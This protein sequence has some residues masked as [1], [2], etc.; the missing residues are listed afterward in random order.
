MLDISKELNH[1]EALVRSLGS[2]GIEVLGG[3]YTGGI[4]LQQSPDEIAPCIMDLILIRDKGRFKNYLEIGAAA[5][6]STYLLNLFFNWDNILLIDDNKHRHKHWKFRKEILKHIRYEEFIGN[7]HTEVAYDFAKRFK[8]DLIFIYGDH[9]YEGIKMDI[10]MYSGLLNKG[11]LLLLHDTI[12]DAFKGVRQA[13]KELKMNRNF[14][15][16]NEYI[17]KKQH[18]LGLGLF[19]KVSG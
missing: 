11:G 4:Y 10:E 6:G 7:S 19:Q 12:V 15:F 9:S 8:F 1:I 2:G 16:I 14:K 17:S 3:D 13:F 5:G 18:K